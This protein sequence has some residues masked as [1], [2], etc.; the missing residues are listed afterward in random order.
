MPISVQGNL[1]VTPQAIVTIDDSGLSAPT[2]GGSGDLI[3]VGVSQGGEPFTPI[4]FRT[5]SEALNTLIAGDGL[6]AVQR[7]FAPAP[8][9]AGAPRVIFIRANNA[10]Q[11][12]LTLQDGASHNSIILASND[13]GSQ[14]NLIRVNIT[15]G[16][17]LGKKI[18]VGYGNNVYIK[19][20]VARGGMTILYNGANLA[21]AAI[22]P[23]S[24]QPTTTTAGGAISAG[25]GVSAVVASSTGIVIG[26]QYLVG[27]AGTATAEV[28]TCSAKA[29]STHFTATFANSH[30]SGEPVIPYIG[31]TGLA[32]NVKTSGS[33]QVPAEC[34]LL[35]TS[36]FT[37]VQSMA[38][39]LN[40][41]GASL[42]T[43]TVQTI[44]GSDSSANFD[45]IN[46]GT[47]VPSSGGL[48]L[49]E[50]LYA[51]LLAFNQNAQAVVTATL[52]TG[53]NQPPANSA[54]A[55]TWTYLSG[56]QDG[57]IPPS[58]QDWTAALTAATTVDCSVICVATG[59][60]TVHAMLQTHVDFESGLAERNERIMIVGGVQGETVSQ[61]VSR[62]NLLRDMRVGLVYPGVIDFDPVTPGT[63][64]IVLDPW[65]VAAQLG[66]MFCGGPIQ[67]AL[68]NQYVSAK[69]LEL[70]LS[71]TDVETLE[72]AGV[73]AIRQIA[74]KGWNVAHSLS[75]WIG[76][77]NYRHNELS[78]MRASDFVQ[79]TVRSAL[80]PLVGQIAA[81]ATML[82]VYNTT[83]TTLTDLTKQG[84]LVGD[85]NSPAFKNLQVSVQG[86]VVTVQFQASVAIPANYIVANISLTPYQGSLSSN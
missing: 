9:F 79:K 27:Y 30:A 24:T 50:N 18:S 48:V 29:D 60:A 38:D 20:N 56:A 32:I 53:A 35:P 73:I 4:Y 78:V 40:S 23:L 65:L 6:R 16:T 44:N 74:N 58:S 5:P 33:A 45:G 52:A 63:T 62:A 81:P 36:Q 13:Y 55:T 15:A 67:N 47:S 34:V 3:I 8:N 71:R 46:A 26:N 10:T 76:D 39:A 7:A 14:T 83:N 77:S 72:L 70:A 85:A 42:F 31:Q 54:S 69:G 82:K 28:V 43:V 25:V 22:G 86:D 75:T 37:T 2:V 1:I 68:T 19:D 57:T 51:C 21:T 84:V 61:A 64:A 49:T 17:N 59:D 11:S 80:D 66:G 12:T 41:K